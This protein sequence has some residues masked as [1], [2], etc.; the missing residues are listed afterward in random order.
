MKEEFHYGDSVNVNKARR[1][2][3]TCVQIMDLLT[4]RFRAVLEFLR[5][6]APHVGILVVIQMVDTRGHH[7][8][9]L[10]PER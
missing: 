7:E 4:L 3:A 9:A 6:Q 1:N 2:C 5:S 10:E 8:Q